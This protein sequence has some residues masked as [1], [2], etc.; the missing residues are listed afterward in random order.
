MSKIFRLILK[1]VVIAFIIAIIAVAALVAYITRDLPDYEALAHYEPAILT[2]V[3]SDDGKIIAEFA[4]KKRLYLPIEAIPPVMKAAFLS[5]EDKGFYNHIG[6]DPKGFVRALLS[7]IRHIGSSRRPVGA[8]TITQQ[9]AKNFLLSSDVKLS[10]KIKEAILAI[11]IEKAYS[12]DHILELYLNEIYLGRGTYG[13]ASAS[14]SYFDKSV[15]DLSLSEIA[16]L[17]ALPKGPAN[18][19]PF[20]KMKKAVT[21]RN[22][23]LDRMHENGYISKEEAE[24]AKQEPLNVVLHRNI[25]KAKGAEYFAEEVRKQ[26]ESRYGDKALYEGGLSIRTTLRPEYQLLAQKA[27]REGL[28][29]HDRNLG[30]RGPIGRIKLSSEEQDEAEPIDWGLQL[31]KYPPLDDVEEW[32]VAVILEINEDNIKVGLQP[33]IDE[34]G[35]ISTQRKEVYINKDSSLWAF[36]NSSG[37]RKRYYNKFSD[38]LNVGDVVYVQKHAY[39]RYTLEQVPRL[40]GALI[41]MEPSTGRVLAM[42]GGFSYKVSQFNRAIQAYRQPGSVFKPFVFAAALDNG[43][44]TSDIL[45]DG[46]ITVEQGSNLEVWKPKNFISDYYAGPRTLRYALEHSLNLFTI[47]LAHIVGVDTVARYAERFKIYDKM[48]RL[49]SMSL[50]AGNTTL[51][52]M[53]T[54]YSMLANGGRDVN[55]TLIDRIQD[56]YGRTIYK[57]DNRKCEGCNA[58]K[59]ETLIEPELIDNR[60]Q[61]LDPLTN[62]QVVNLLE[63]VIQSGTGRALRNLKH[64][65]AGKTGTSNAAKDAWFIAFTPDL[66]VGVY[67]GY[68]MPKTLDEKGSGS[69]LVGPII[70]Q[71]LEEVLKDM[72][73]SNFQVP[74]GITFVPINQQT[75]M[76]AEAFDKNISMDPFKPGSKPADSYEILGSEVFKR[77]VALTPASPA[78]TNALSEGKEGLF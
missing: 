15:K 47:R 4:T 69:G 30:W 60:Q 55:P 35:K 16:Y 5:A 23:V 42:V 53:S 31:Q 6:I 8:S 41:A 43:F 7:N 10:R 77:G 51:M 2:R 74:R 73:K 36:R 54:A 67:L 38:F 70:Q 68:D 71:F 26:I 12:K 50:G 22:W 27:L 72:R 21:R 45:N 57:H 18:Y 20:T 48:P 66:L 44:R 25:N 52:R 61:I 37:R 64:P 1:S 40:E 78:A 39:G 34:T 19:N 59:P 13:V 32:K 46:P 9:V 58:I 24:A 76:R 75:G 63:G 3:H 49:L 17:A 29:K 56:R 33:K 62:Y 28:I 14:L 65:L 11:K